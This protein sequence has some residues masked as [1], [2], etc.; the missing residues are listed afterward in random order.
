MHLALSVSLHPGLAG[1]SSSAVRLCNGS[2]NPDGTDGLEITQGQGLERMRE[3][4]GKRE[5]M[6]S[7]RECGNS[8]VWTEPSMGAR[9]CSEYWWKVKPQL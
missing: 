4:E 3:E 2:G 7:E 9:I 1:N 5:G 6:G 8:G